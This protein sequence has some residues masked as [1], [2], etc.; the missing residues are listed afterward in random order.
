M[1]QV[2]ILLLQRD[3]TAVFRALARARIIHLHRMEVAGAEEEGGEKFGSDLLSRYAAFTGLLEKIMGEM[4]IAGTPGKLLSPG[5]FPGWESWAVQLRQRL[6]ILRRRHEQL[7]RMRRYC[8]MLSIFTR[9]LSRIEGDFSELRTLRFS[10][11]R[12]GVVPTAALVELPLTVAGLAIYPL[13]ET[14][15]NLLV[16]LLSPRRSQA[17]LERSLAESGMVMLP[18]PRHLSGSFPE[19][20]ARLGTLQKKIRRRLRRLESKMSKLR[21]ENETLLRDRLHT[22]EVENRLLKAGDE[23]GHTGRTVAIGG[24]VP[25]RRLSELRETLDAGCSG[26]FILHHTRALGEETPVQ[27]FNPAILRPFQKLLSILGTPTYGEVE[28]TPLL[29]LGFLVLFGMMFGDVGQGLVFLAAGLIMRRFTP[30][31]DA[32][33]IVAEVGIFA[34]LFGFLFGSFFGREDLF[35]PLWFSP[36]HDIPRLMLASLL[37]GV[38]L[39]L[40]GLLLRILNGLRTERIRAVLTDRFGVAGLI[41]YAGSL[42]TAVFIYR[43]ILPPASL[44][45]L[46][47]PLAAIFC[48]PFAERES[49]WAP[50]GMLLAEGGI[51]VLET[52]LGFLANTFSFL[53]VAAFGLAHV[54]LFMAVFAVAD[55]VRQAAFGPLWVALVHV[56]GNA[57][58]LV[59]EGLVVSIQAVRLEF[60]E[61][62]SKFF[63]GTGVAYRPLALEPGLERRDRDAR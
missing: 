53:R 23:L 16:A 37:L 32:G 22:I 9:R 7:T 4:G 47:A 11:L 42:A 15:G 63:R 26:R 1:A 36:F 14:G 62:F 6:S 20:S 10:F 29:A 28:P 19:A 13:K 59:L 58:I 41:F 45:W 49:K 12:L 60:Y 18:L 17:D 5:D 21:R 55:Q 43:G 35:E 51:E 61:I 44:L 50:T 34:A 56:A 38:S 48:H 40:T 39:I 52:V 57:V 24:W 8:A 30:L 27:F 2:E 46:A 25:Q 31:R 33:L 54:G 3:L